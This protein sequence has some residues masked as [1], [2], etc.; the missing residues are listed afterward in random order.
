MDTTTVGGFSLLSIMTEVVAVEAAG[1]LTVKTT[2]RG[3]QSSRAQ[4]RESGVGDS[5]FLTVHC[6]EKKKKK[7]YKSSMLNRRRR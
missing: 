4:K 5:I 1:L 3:K 6:S 7:D 2:A